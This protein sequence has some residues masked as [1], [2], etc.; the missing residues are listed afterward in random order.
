MKTNCMKALFT[1]FVAMSM[2][3]GLFA[4]GDAG[5]VL[6]INGAERPFVGE[7]LFA[8]VEGRTPTGYI[9]LRSDASGE[10]NEIISR[11]QSYNPSENDYGHWLKAVACISDGTSLTNAIFFSRLPVVYITGEMP[12]DIGQG[13]R[14]VMLRMQ[15]N[16]S[17][18]ESYVGASQ[19][20][21]RGNSTS[22]WPK[23]PY[24][25]KLDKKA[26]PYG[27]GTSK[28]KH[29]VLLANFL[30]QSLMR[31][32][33][34]AEI[35]DIFGVARMET[36][37]V[38][39]VANGT[40]LGNYQLCEHVRVAEDRVDIFDWEDYAESVAKQVWDPLQSQWTAKGIT[41]KDDLKTVFVENLSWVN[42]GVMSLTNGQV[43]LSD[44]IPEIKTL[45]LSGGYLYEME[46]RRDEVTS[47]FTHD[48]VHINIIKPEYAI[49]SMAMMDSAI[50]LVNDAE[51]AWCSENGEDALGR[52]YADLADVDSMVAFWLVNEIMGNVD[53]SNGG[54]V[55]IDRGGKIVFGPVW[56]FDWG[57]G[58][59][60]VGISEIGWK[61]SLKPRRQ[62]V[63]NHWLKHADFRAAARTAYLAHR[64]ELQ[65]LFEDGG[66]FETWRGYLAESGVADTSIWSKKH[67]ET[68]E[69]Y[70]DGRGFLLDSEL[71]GKY[72]TKRLKWLDRQFYSERTF[73]ESV[74]ATNVTDEISQENTSTKPAYVMGAASVP[75]DGTWTD[76]GQVTKTD[77]GFELLLTNDVTRTVHFTDDLG[78]LVLDM[79]GYSIT[80]PESCAAVQV[81]HRNGTGIHLKIVNSR[82]SVTACIN[83]GSGGVDRYSLNV[84]GPGIEAMSN[85]VEVVFSV[86][87]NVS[88]AGADIDIENF[89]SGDWWPYCQNGPAG[90]VGNVKRNDG[91]IVG[92]TGSYGATCMEDASHCDGTGI[93]GGDGGCGVNGNV[94][95]NAGLIAAGRGGDVL[96]HDTGTYHNSSWNPGFCG[97]GG[98]GVYGDVK[99]NSGVIIGGAGGCYS[100]N[101]QYECFAYPGAGGA[102]VKGVVHENQ[103]NAK[104]SGGVGGYWRS[105]WE[106][107]GVGGCAVDGSVLMNNG[108]ITNGN[109]GGASLTVRKSDCIFNGAEHYLDIEIS[110]LPEWYELSNITF[111]GESVTPICS[112]NGKYRIHKPLVDAG[113]YSPICIIGENA[114]YNCTDLKE[115]VGMTIH[116]KDFSEVFVGDLGSCV[117]SGYT[118]T[119]MPV[120]FDAERGVDLEFGKDYTISY[121]NNK[122]A[123]TATVTVTGKG[124]YSGSVSKTFTIAKAEVTPPVLAVKPYT[125]SAQTATV[126]ASSLY[127]V[128]QNIPQTAPGT[129]PVMLELVDPA[130]YRWPDSESSLY[131]VSFTITSKEE[132]DLE[133][134]FGD[135]PAE[136]E[137]DANG[138]WIVTLTDD[139]AG[140]VEIFG[141]LGGVTIDLNG[142]DIIGTDNEPAIRI[143][144]GDGDGSATRLS[145]VTGGGDSLVQGGV[146]SPAIVVCEGVAGIVI[147]IGKGVTVRAGSE[148][149][150]SISGGEIGENEG[151]LVK[152]KV[153]VPVL[154]EL[155]YTGSPQVPV[156]SGTGIYT[157]SVSSGTNPG[158]YPIMATL[159]QPDA[160]EWILRDGAT[161]V[162]ATAIFTFTILDPP[163][164]IDIEGGLAQ[165]EAN[166]ASVKAVYDGR[167]HGISVTVVNP[168]TGATVRY[169]AS[170]AGPFTHGKP[171]FTNVV[172]GAETWFE[173]SAAGFD[174]VTN[175]ATVTVEA[176]PLSQS[177]VAVK[178]LKENDEGEVVPVI[179][180]SD[181]PPCVVSQGDWSL[182]SW[183]P[184]ASGGGTAVI[185][186]S[187]NYTGT[188]TIDVPNEM[189]VVF[190]AVYGSSEDV[191]TVTTQIPGRPYALP[192][193]APVYRGHDFLGWFTERDGGEE[194]TSSR[195]VSLSDPDVVY[196]HWRVRTSRITYE[197][198]GG[199]GDAPAFDAQ[200]GSAFAELP[201]VSRPGYLF[202]GWWTTPG[203]ER[204]TQVSVGD[205]YPVSDATLYAKWL[206]RA[207][208]YSDSVFHLEAAAVYNGYLVDTDDGDVV[209]GTIQVKASKPNKKT[210]FSKLTVAISIAGEKK[211]TIKGE[212]F[213][214]TLKAVAKDGREL[215][216]VLG[217]SALVGTFGRY[218]VDGGRNIFTAKDEDSKVKAAQALK[219]W[220]GT[221]MLAWGDESGWNGLSLAV[222]AKGKTKVSGSLS[223]GT[224][225]SA[226]TQL[227]KG[228]RE[229]AVAVSWTKK[230]ASVSFLVWFCEDG[231]VECSNLKGG[232]RA[233]VAN[234]R[235]GAYLP[236]GSVFRMDS[237]SLGLSL[238]GIC[239]DVHP[240]GQAV[241]MKGDK[242]DVDKAGKV[243]LL[244]DKSGLDMSKA[245]TNPS[246]L[247]LTYK[248]KDGTFKGSFCVYAITGGRLKKYKATVS[249]VVLGGKGYGTATIKKLGSWAVTIE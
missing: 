86:G 20:K 59:V 34:A 67:E 135:L 45:D 47:F 150:P 181:T 240:D 189:L 22:Q 245:G 229:C 98:V 14:N 164:A 74:G 214:G 31:N 231:T 206:R 177:M 102:A 215:D 100:G 66:L 68:F 180:L 174:P 175:M 44:V 157:V 53:A 200:Y 83:G 159:V 160:Y 116:C 127:R 209:S 197:L 108:M 50:A 90:I 222:G 202:D 203:F 187:G 30:D 70:G 230:N 95:E 114:K 62:C 185:R 55:H 28:N 172:H 178:R 69:K 38:D 139:I 12:T 111:G 33:L 168:P 125:G 65:A 143:V 72:M 96:L 234:I 77:T 51:A 147:N 243:K 248:I 183:E 75:A 216:I 146:N 236:E 136:L 80:G 9:W 8:V 36:I 154:P 46:I 179:E 199:A 128:V 13:Y 41:S 88:V 2:L 156:L 105:I 131:S 162:G 141:N 129:Y 79:N 237:D 113:V 148:D 76:I 228:E 40:Y 101:G 29:W 119:P 99:I 193:T 93:P 52:H 5:C 218:A 241:R 92:G 126:P 223:D 7:S 221:Y 195:T 81:A 188:L 130:N 71:L 204:G 213:D 191:R 122:N 151:T 84:G 138:G 212:T 25:L 91:I 35:A 211:V 227:L 171:L 163:P 89:D 186:G 97:I 109:A 210:G 196:A 208:W 73:A 60:A 10:N 15:G 182:V 58:S 11:S 158:T 82:D 18:Q 57:A 201:S 110:N 233:I 137:P 118:Y 123:G 132:K 17:H 190:D 226:T 107:G 42:T 49:T 56:D 16:E 39:V 23:K 144:K 170:P 134:I 207:L 155:E 140:P 192:P 54:Y 244:K 194:V 165:G 32:A 87:Q 239:R 169:S 24:K 166:G 78:E 167:G 48:R 85:A 232:A 19:L 103:S 27:L 61:C 117:Y 246:G 161:V 43:N 37:W 220:Q 205:S 120:V 106:S 104:I 247:K 121:S 1:S 4:E 112:G 224:K 6:S 145:L 225:V 249:G 94:E 235:S 173:I 219:S 198:N 184:R 133:E 124:N 153:P 217:E 115:M 64:A 176:K 63:F 21:V 3:C 238:P 26:N 142:Y 152:V 149:I 242:F